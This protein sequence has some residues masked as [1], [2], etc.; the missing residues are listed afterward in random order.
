MSLNTRDF[1]QGGQ[2]LKYMI[3]MFLQ[4]MNI[5]AYWIFILSFLVFATWLFIK[6][7]WEQIVHGGCYWLIKLFVIPL[8]KIFKEGQWNPYTFHF[9]KADGTTYA[10]TRNAAQVVSDPYFIALGEM[11]KTTAF[12]GWGIASFTFVGAI[13]GVTWYLG[14]K[15]RLQRENEMIG[16]RDLVTDVKVVNKILKKREKLS[17]LSLS[18]LHFVKY[19]EMQNFGLHGTV[20]TGKSTILNEFLSQIRANGD[21]AIVYDKGNNFIPLFYRQDRDVILNPLDKRCAAWNLWDECQT[22][23]DYENFATTLIPDSGQGDPFWLLSARNLFSATARRLAKEGDRSIATLLKKLLSITLADLRAFLEGTDAANL[24]EGSIE[25][26]AMTIR[27]VL[28]SYVRAL[29]YLQGLDEA[30]KRPFNLRD[31]VATEDPEGDNSWVFVSSDGRNHNALKPLI[32]AWLYLTMVNILGLSASRTRRIWLILDELPSLHKLPIL[33]EF[34]AESRKF[35][36]C[37]FIPIQNFPQLKEIYGA[38]FAEAIW[39]LVN[40]RFFFRA[41]SG[42]VSDWVEHEIGE[43]RHLKFKDQY[44]YG[45][46]IIRDGVQ[47]SKD[48]VRESLVSYSDIQSLNDLQCY[49][50]LPGD[51]PVVKLDLKR[52]EY[53]SIAVDHIPRQVEEIFDPDIETSLENAESEV[54]NLTAKLLN[55]VF[56]TQS[57]SNETH[58]D[59]GKPSNQEP[60][61]EDSKTAGIQTAR[62]QIINDP[63]PEMTKAS[64]VATPVIPEHADESQMVRHRETPAFEIER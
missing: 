56:N 13:F 28:T 64:S 53:R 31:W 1:T 61:D 44:S 62:P 39:D 19:S 38:N 26:T 12:W 52:R 3:G 2:V 47:F 42:V 36:G 40:T 10:F 45:I 35:G 24:V 9:T 58:Q 15:G 7:T 49:V 20:G 48:E 41:P 60:S 46:D 5:A 6:M 37:T 59:E 25:K 63:I 34:C 54:D 50:T 11:F 51:Y 4:I 33:P 16:G 8:R 27:T 21:R 43:K 18:G 17:H 32:T 55:K 29:R 23:S 22:S 57:E 14:R 30:G